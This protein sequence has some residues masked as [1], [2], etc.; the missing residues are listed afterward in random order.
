MKKFI[1]LLL[2]TAVIHLPYSCI[3]EDDCGDFTPLESRITELTTSI[4]SFDND[5][6]SNI[7]SNSFNTAA[8]KIEITEMEFQEIA[9]YGKAH[10]NLFTNQAV[11]CSPPVPELAYDITNISITG[12][13]EISIDGE[14]MTA[15][16][17]LNSLFKVPDSNDITFDTFVQNLQE[18]KWQFGYIG[19]EFT[20]VLVNQPD[21][22]LDQRFKIR[23]DFSDGTFIEVETD[24]FKV[25]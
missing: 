23:F 13:S 18:N 3:N 14:A 16:E 25:N 20:L 4:G 9:A 19:A 15:G 2:L 10:L 11:A 6:F 12:E 5:G 22:P 8:I 21:E 24:N 17:S 1:S 7:T